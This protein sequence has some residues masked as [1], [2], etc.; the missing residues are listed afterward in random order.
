MILYHGSTEAISLPK[1]IVPNRTLDFGT[2]FYTTTSPNQATR[3]VARK[4][5]RDGSATRTGFLN[6]YEL[7]EDKMKSLDVLWFDK[8][9]EE[10]LDFVMK[11]RNNA[12]FEHHHDLVYSP[13]ANDR[14]YAAFA[15]FEGG[16]LNKAELISEL[17]TYKLIDQM[18]FHT[19]KSLECLTFLKAEKICYE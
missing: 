12:G 18:L 11:N 13:V 15:L 5:E 6:V 2:G 8:A 17:R 9:D 7:N 14:V 10:W 4:I 19:R 3:W 1:I 16:F